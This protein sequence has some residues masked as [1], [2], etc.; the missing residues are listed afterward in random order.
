MH[1]LFSTL[2]VFIFTVG[3]CISLVYHTN[4][5]SIT[6]QLVLTVNGPGT[7]SGS[8]ATISCSAG[9]CSYSFNTGTAVTLLATPYS[10][11]SF[12]GW[13]GGS[14]TGSN[15]CPLTL[16]GDTSISATFVEGPAKVQIQ[17]ATPRFYPLLQTALNHAIGG[18]ILRVESGVFHEDILL[19][20]TG[21]LNLQAGY[22]SSFEIQSGVT[23]LDGTLTIAS[24][25]LT[26][27]GIT[28]A[29][30]I[31]AT[32]PIANAGSDHLSFPGWTVQLDGTGSR[33]P[34]MS[35]LTYHWDLAAKPQGSSTALFSTTTATP[36]F[37]PDLPGIYVAR[38]IVNNGQLDSTADTA[39]ITVQ[40][41][42]VPY[43]ANSLFSQPEAAAVA[44]TASTFYTSEQQSTVLHATLKTFNTA[45]T[46]GVYT[47]DLVNQDIDPNDTWVPEVNAHFISDDYPDDNVA[48]NATLRLRGNSARLAD[49]KSYRVKL[50][51]D[52][53]SVQRYWRNETTLQ[54]NK[55]PWDLSRVRNKLAFDLFRDIPHLPSLRTQFMQISIDDENDSNDGDYGLFTHVEKLGKE[56]LTN[57]GLAT[58]G[59][60]YKANDFTFRMADGLTLGSDGKKPLDKTAFEL[61]LEIEN[62]NTDHRP[63][64]AMINAVNTETATIN[65][66]I[67]TYFN[68]NNYITWLATN[69][70]TGNRDTINQNFELYQP[71]GTTTFYFIPWDYDGALGF[72]NQPDV[73]AANNLYAPWQMG[74]GNWW[75]IPLHKRF[76]MD[77][78]NRADLT[79]TV[80]DLYSTYLTPEKIKTLLD[81]YKPQVE[82]II[83]KSPDLD[84]LPTV[85]GSESESQ[86]AHEY[87]RLATVI[88]INLD[89]YLASLD[90][91]MPFWQSATVNGTN[92]VL[93]W[94]PAIDLQ[95]RAITYDI[96][97][98]TDPAFG[99]VIH[100]TTAYSD[101]SLTIPKP[102]AGTYYLRVIAKNTIGQTTTGFDRYDTE[103]TT[104]WGV[105]QFT[106]S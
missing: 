71:A 3:I 42:T 85:S 55:H 52:A 90:Q 77:A 87:A 61:I 104:Y 88:K 48:I 18:E 53:N 62:V 74:I 60:I 11:S 51:K 54:L 23:Q 27:D 1:R 14:C 58:D 12:A 68:R 69:I 25:C 45:Y 97:V 82:P 81:S 72:E 33:D 2:R 63:L 6:N 15:S 59:N 98:S 4:A 93:E 38:L 17:G 8:P 103:G 105:L 28:I 30:G 10:G 47:F 35:S 100:S 84:H 5:A 101:T 67:A 31:S 20:S 99:T 95:G 56:Y 80:M 73:Q 34:N 19:T 49:Q 29:A 102:A 91:P 7:I 79:R 57:R 36:T 9:S 83:T 89:R 46:G 92:L 16:S 39:T 94:N 66:T 26:V 76:L 86:W 96:Q 64:I 65:E 43:S 106:V 70:L 21:Q 44:D 32:Q 78:T 37:T 50:S 40:Q 22:N 41:V 13:L 75:D 24:G